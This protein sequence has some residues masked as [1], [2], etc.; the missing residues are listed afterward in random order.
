M[1]SVFGLGNPGSR[2]APTRHNVGFQVVETL[3]ERWRARS[4]DDTA[5]YRW[6]TAER[7]GREVSLV[8][9]LTFMNGSG[10]AVATYRERHGLEPEELLVVADD[11]YLPVGTLRLRA[12]GSSG[13]HRGLESIETALETDEYARLRIGVG[14]ADNAAA[15]RDHV[16]ETF[17]EDERTEIEAALG[18]AVEVV[19]CWAD[20]G[21]IAAMNRFNRRVGKEVSEP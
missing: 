13:G 15:L 5:E 3:V 9:P 20:D 16:L 12:R 21:V 1:P 19:E 6:W 10:L 2:Y 4:R 11:V 17:A 18:R 7:N 14:A 8:Q